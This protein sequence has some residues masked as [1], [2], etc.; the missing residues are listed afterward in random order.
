MIKNEIPPMPN[1][2]TQQSERILLSPEIINCIKN[3]ASQILENSQT[4]QQFCVPGT[5]VF[6]MLVVQGTE[7]A[8]QRKSDA[9]S[10]VLE[11]IAVEGIKEKFILARR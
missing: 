7:S 6:Y 3:T 9:G 4:E 2:M 10:I 11:G 8:T 5:Q 1:N